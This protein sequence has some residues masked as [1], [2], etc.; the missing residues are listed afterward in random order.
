MATVLEEY[1]TEE[2]NSVVRFYGQ[3]DSVQEIFIEKCPVY[4]GKCLSPKAF[5]N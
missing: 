3:Q 2:Q 1:A 5:H 4:G